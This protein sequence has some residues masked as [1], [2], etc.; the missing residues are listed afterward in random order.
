MDPEDRTLLK[1]LLA[2]QRLV[3]L[4]LVV[5]GDPV[6]GLL[7]FVVAE[8]GRALYVQASGLA[9][10]SRGLTAGAPFSAV[11]HRPDDP[12]G[13]A[14]QTPRVVLEGV[15]DPLDGERPEMAAAVRG[16]LERFPSA[17][18]TLALPDFKVYRLELRGGRLIG[19][20]GRALNLALS[21]F[22]DLARG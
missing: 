3:A 20:F 18:M 11:I 21:H 1:S 8:D 4:G 13:D 2:H 22:E 6:V 7:P 10:H 16:L 12:E 9:R 14:L 15:V 17:A 5:D 19:G